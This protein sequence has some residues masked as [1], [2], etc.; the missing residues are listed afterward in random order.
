MSSVYEMAEEVLIWLGPGNEETS[1]LIKAIDYIDKK[2]KEAYRGSNIKD[3]IGLCRSSMIEELG[4]RGPQLHSKR[5]SVLAGLLENDWFKR[6]WI[7]Q[8]IAN[9]KTAKIVC[10]NSSCPARTFSF[11]PFL[12]E[13]PVDEHVQPVLDIM[14]RI[15]TGTWWSSTRH[16]HYLLQKFSGSQATEERDKVYALLSM[17]EDAKDSKRFF[18]CYVKAE[19]QVWRDTVSFLIMGE[20]LDHNHSFPKFTFPDLRLPIIQLAEQTL[21]WALTQVGSNRDSARRTAMILVD[22]LNEGQLKRHELLQSLAKE[23]GQEE[24]MQ[25]LLSHDNYHIDINFL[26]EQTTLQVT[27]RELAM[28]TVKVVFPQAN[29]ATVKRQAE[30][31][32]FKPPSF[33]YKDDENMAETISRLVEEGSPAQEMLWAHAWAGNS[34]AVRQ[35]LETGVDVSGADDEGN[36]AIHFAAARGRLDV[37]K[38]LLENVLI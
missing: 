34:D 35:L 2:A 25:S 1:N 10:G 20:I 15:R 28:D 22:R 24:K 6:V 32:A 3:W 4:S 13:L 14:P 18:P 37:V 17:S 19:K 12:M 33:R 21:K 8:E 7:L 11:M 31:D 23:H 36:A 5:Q 26:D 29:L 9:A 38:L 27:S 16:L 30:L